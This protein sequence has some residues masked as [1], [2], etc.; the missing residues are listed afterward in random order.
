MIIYFL[1]LF[2]LRINAN[3]ATLCE[4]NN[5][6]VEYPENRTYCVTTDPEVW[7]DTSYSNPSNEMYIYRV[8]AN[9]CHSPKTFS[10]LKRTDG[11]THIRLSFNKKTTS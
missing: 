2:F 5:T 10:D 1:F 11:G 9:N 3:N 4:I 7:L 6:L 8:W